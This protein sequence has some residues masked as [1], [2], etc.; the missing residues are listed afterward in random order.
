[1]STTETDTH[2]PPAEAPAADLPPPTAKTIV[3]G[4]SVVDIHGCVGSSDDEAEN[5][6]NRTGDVPFEWYAGE[7]HM[8]YGPDGT[9][10]AKSDESALDALLFSAQ[11]GNIERYKTIVDRMHSDEKIVLSDR[12][13]QILHNIQTNRYPSLSYTPYQDLPPDLC[14]ISAEDNPFTRGVASRKIYV[15]RPKRQKQA[16]QKEPAPAPVF[17][18]DLWRDSWRRRSPRYIAAPEIPLPTSAESYNPPLELLPTE[19][20]RAA[21]LEKNSEASSIRAELLPRRHDCL[22]RVPW[23]DATLSERYQRCLDLFSFPRIRRQK[24]QIANPD[25][26]LPRLPPPRD[27]RPFPEILAMEYRGH[28]AAVRSLSVSPSGQWLATGCDDH[29]LRVFEISTGRIVK[30]YDLRAPVAWVQFGPLESCPYLAAAVGSEIRF[31]AASV[32]SLYSPPDETPEEATRRRRKFQRMF[33]F[34]SVQSDPLRVFAESGDDTQGAA[35][36][37][38]VA[39]LADDDFAAFSF[40]RKDEDGLLLTVHLHSAVRTGCIHHGGDYVAVVAP[41][42]P[43]RQRRVVLLQLETQ[44]ALCPFQ[45]RSLCKDGTRIVDCRFFEDTP[46]FLVVTATA[47][48]VFDLKAQALVRRLRPG[49]RTS[50]V[51]V[52]AHPFSGH[53]VCSSLGDAQRG[54]M[55]FD[56]DG[57]EKPAHKFPAPF[58]GS[59]MLSIAFHR[60]ARRYPLL[61]LGSAAGR[62]SVF[63][64]A[65]VVEG[66]D[67][68]QTTPT[69]VPLR[70][71]KFQSGAAVLASVFHPKLPWIFTASERGEVAAWVEV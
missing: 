47:G 23:Y 18:F 20:E 24:L 28:T 45:L 50:L 65:S 7:T 61:A 63:H 48:Y 30:R 6:L 32:A 21:I 16:A 59:A 43:V 67:A 19:G 42:D 29:L 52:D 44:Q 55:F 3:V 69:L 2:Q 4:K 25:D 57:G 38:T 27:L 36:P 49:V 12:D 71:L 8:G 56:R 62:V 11:R 13:I 15:P 37:E 26:L 34:A 40:P 68:L 60:S 10:L 35:V 1:M 39:R 41:G 17:D 31:F 53:V 51:A 58:A 22:R 9:R 14:R 64:A 54:I 70:N 5:P 33:S 46:E 66:D